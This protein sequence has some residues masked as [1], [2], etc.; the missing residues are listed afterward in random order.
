MADYLLA[1]DEQEAFGDWVVVDGDFEV[2]VGLTTALRVS[3]FTDK[4]AREE[5]RIP[6]RSGDPRGF[7]GNEYTPDPNDEY[8][9][10]LWLLD[11]KPLT[12]ETLQ[13]MED[14]AEDAVAWMVT[15]GI[16][17]KVEATAQKFLEVDRT[18][19]LLEIRIYRNDDAPLRF[20]FKRF[21]TKAQAA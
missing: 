15:D 17:R 14:Y 5:D 4:R 19:A 21:W 9:S 12:A 16:A 10:W 6:D 7:W 8:G 3:L 2:D 18:A 13:Q 11:G 20:R 1:W